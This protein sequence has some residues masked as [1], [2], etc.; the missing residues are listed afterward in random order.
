MFADMQISAD[1][2]FL[3]F[4]MGDWSLLLGGFALI[5]LLVWLV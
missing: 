3:A 2:R 1:G 4:N 5:G